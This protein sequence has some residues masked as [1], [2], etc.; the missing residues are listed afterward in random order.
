MSIWLSFVNIW[1]V[2]NCEFN[3]NFLTFGGLYYLFFELETIE[4][5]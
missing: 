1:T 2:C 3:A 4:A 5:S